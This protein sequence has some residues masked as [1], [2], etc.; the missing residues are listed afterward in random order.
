MDSFSGMLNNAM[1]LVLMGF[2]YD[3]T[4]LGRPNNRFRIQIIRG[5]VLGIIS[6]SIMLNSWLLLPGVIFDTRSVILSVGSLFFGLIPSAIMTVMT[7][8]YRFY[9]G[10][11]GVWAGNAVILASSLIGLTWRFL[12]RR[13]LPTFSTLEL[14]LLGI[15]VHVVMLL[16]MLILPYKTAIDV[17]SKISL[18]VMIIYPITTVLAGKLLASRLSRKQAEQLLAES[19]KKFRR[20]VDYAPEGI[21]VTNE[22]GQYID[23]NPMACE[24][25]G[26]TRQ[27]LLQK[28]LI[29][30]IS[31]EDHPVAISLFERLIQTGVPIG[32]ISYCRKNGEKRFWKVSCV[33]LSDTEFLVFT[34]DITDRI[35]TEEKLK[36][37]LAEKELLIREL[38]HRTKNNM[39]IIASMLYLKASQTSHPEIIEVFTEIQAKIQSMSLIHYRLYQSK[40]LRHINLKDYFNDLA[41][42]M[43]DSFSST[44]HSVL[45][46][47]NLQSVVVSLDTAIP[48]G[49]IINE[50]VS[51]AF[52]YAFPGRNDGKITINLIQKNQLICLDIAD[53]GIGLPENFD[54]L[55]QGNWGTKLISALVESQLSG[56]LSWKSWDGLSFH[57]EFTNHFN[58]L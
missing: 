17:L 27:E 9:Q 18:P 25:T 29:H 7:G 34:T 24:Q 16:C 55:K 53:N 47:L 42:L 45:I 22:Q 30:L 50:I 28:N 6:I 54:L 38:Y 19:E 48:C 26:Y 44:A 39:Q 35:Q 57:I 32:D 58:S 31:A 52:K 2:L 11:A 3:L 40:D 51:N 13:H 4:E 20:Y 46:E 43:K 15:T 14:Y 33:K 41:T 21:W 12:R 1:L 5:V 10:G 56:K 23:V 36:S 37:A 49:L 8:S